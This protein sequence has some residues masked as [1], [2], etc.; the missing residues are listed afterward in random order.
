RPGPWRSF[1]LASDHACAIDDADATMY[2]W[3][4]NEVDQI[5]TIGAAYGLATAHA[6][7]GQ[8]VAVAVGPGATCAVTLDRNLVC[9]GDVSTGMV[10]TA[11]AN[12]PSYTIDTSHRWTAIALG[13]D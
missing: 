3:G 8:V 7:G 12:T 2:C 10:G 9:G 11:P 6:A 5:D 13:H 4:A 1:A